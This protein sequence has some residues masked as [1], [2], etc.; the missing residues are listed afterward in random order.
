MANI[1]VTAV[2]MLSMAVLMMSFLDEMQL[3]QQK[4]QVSQLARHFLLRMETTG[5]MTEEDRQDLERELTELGVTEADLSGTS[6][7]P[8]GYGAKI[9]LQIRGKLGGSNAF[10]ERRVST[11]KY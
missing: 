4:A 1:M 5:G 2:F 9:V 11:A 7:G 6:F 3:I 10:E 8:S